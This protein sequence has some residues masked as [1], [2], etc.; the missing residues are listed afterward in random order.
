[1]IVERADK[2]FAVLSLKKV[3]SAWIEKGFFS[4]RPTK[5]GGRRETRAAS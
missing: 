5:A 1:V 3:S 2:I 4:L